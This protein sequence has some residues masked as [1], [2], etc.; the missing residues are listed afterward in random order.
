MVILEDYSLNYGSILIEIGSC[1]VLET[2]V[3]T[4]DAKPICRPRPMTPAKRNNKYSLSRLIDNDIVESSVE[5][6]GQAV[7]FISKKTENYR[8]V[9]DFRPINLITVAD[10]YPL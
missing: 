4:G 5:I 1:D 6:L 3:D 8:L 7:R 9:V 10:S 2:H